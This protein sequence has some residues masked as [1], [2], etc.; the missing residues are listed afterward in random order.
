MLL[1][2]RIEFGVLL[3]PLAIPKS[4]E[5]AG[6]F[7]QSHDQANTINVLTPRNRKGCNGMGISQAG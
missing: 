4:P 7:L 1:P 5:R 6:M 3:D 2:I